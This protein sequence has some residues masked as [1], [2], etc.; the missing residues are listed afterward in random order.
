MEMTEIKGS[1]LISI[2]KKVVGQS[3]QTEMVKMVGLNSLFNGVK[4][5]LQSSAEQ[6][7][8]A[9]L[10]TDPKGGG[11]SGSMLLQ[12]LRE[13]TSDGW[14]D[15][16]FPDTKVFRNNQHDQSPL[17]SVKAAISQAFAPPL[18]P[19]ATVSTSPTIEKNA[20]GLAGAEPET[21][22]LLFG[23]MLKAA[24]GAII[25]SK[26]ISKIIIEWVYGPGSDKS[27]KCSGPILR[28]WQDKG[29]LEVSGKRTF[30]LGIPYKITAK[31]MVNFGLDLESEQGI[32]TAQNQPPGTGGEVKAGLK[33]NLVD[34]IKMVKEKI[35]EAAEI[36]GKIKALEAEVTEINAELAILRKSLMDPSLLQ[37]EK[38]WELVS[39]LTKEN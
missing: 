27:G 26:Q 37:A 3:G 8:E 23:E 14:F 39:K 9:V 18:T 34:E 29:W 13:K 5:K 20:R 38:L 33:Y 6:C 24:N 28:S 17:T 12:K 30:S 32:S 35:K 15:P 22:K 21:L 19:P 36:K 4:I 16:E 10:S 11:I 7:Y 1:Y 2:K 25:S 31:A